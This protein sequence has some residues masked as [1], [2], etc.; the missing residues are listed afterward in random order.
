[1]INH[2]M[3][4]LYGFGF[5]SQVLSAIIASERCFCI[6]QPLR[7]QTV[8]RT[9][10]TIA[11]IV[12][13]NIVVVGLFFLVMFRYRTSCAYDPVS[14]KTFILEVAGQFYLDHRKAIENLDTIVF[15]SFLPGATMAVVTTTTMITT[16]KLRQAA[17]WRAEMSSS[18]RMTSQEIALTK[19][20]VGC[21]V[22]FIVA[23]SPLVSFRLLASHVPFCT[24]VSSFLLP[25]LP[26]ARPP[27]PLPPLIYFLLFVST[28]ACWIFSS[29]GTPPNSDMDH[30]VINVR[31][32]SFLCA[33]IHTGVADEH[34]TPTTSQL[35]IFDSEKL[36]QICLVLLTGFE[37]R[38]FG[39]RV[40]RSTN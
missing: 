34:T 32:R 7:S 26:F 5:V 36:S 16:I 28:S 8:L 9:S 4:A 11:I 30:M 3:L 6:L 33:R 23:V 10:T 29:F 2:N 35:N 37:D 20:L 12:V 40:R 22:F 17:A 13:V 21:S 1:M 27:P 38:V 19:M 14:Q 18:V 15:G 25:F 31:N 24:S 39:S